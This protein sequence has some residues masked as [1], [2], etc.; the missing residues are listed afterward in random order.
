MLRIDHYTLT[1]DSVLSYHKACLTRKETHGDTAQANMS[2]RRA[3][4]ICKAKITRGL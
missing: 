3:S 1:R 4:E 2:D